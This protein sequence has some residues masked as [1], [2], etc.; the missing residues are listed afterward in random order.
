MSKAHGTT[1]VL[2]AVATYSIRYIGDP[3]LTQ[4]ASEI[5][6][7]DGKLVNLVD[8]MF[9]VMYDAPGMGL[10]A[11]Q[12]GVQKR[13]F[14]YEYDEQPGVLINP[15]ISESDESWTF[16]EG[17]LSI[18]GLYFEIVR[19]KKVLIT[20]VD[21]DGNEVTY[22]ADEL[23]ARLFQHELDHLDGTLMTE[24]LTEEQRKVAKKH[25]LDLRLNGPSPH[26]SITLGVDGA[27]IERP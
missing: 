10:A 27:I 16:N 17:C 14:V 26:P 11:P 5:N 6:D 23:Q 21:L 15:V 20:G 2:T 8:E 25:L 24:H 7:I 12:I 19:P 13:L 22:E 1:V 3:V 4:R 9:D 18:P